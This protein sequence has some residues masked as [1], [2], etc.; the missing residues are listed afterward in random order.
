MNI[1]QLQRGLEEQGHRVPYREG[2]WL[3][4]LPI[5]VPVLTC[6]KKHMHQMPTEKV[7]QPLGCSQSPS[8]QEAR[9]YFVIPCVVWTLPPP[10]CIHYYIVI[11]SDNDKILISY[12]TG[13]G[14]KVF[15]PSVHFFWIITAMRQTTPACRMTPK[16]DARRFK[17][18]WIR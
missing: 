12:Q 8:T 16:T 3:H 4:Y 15:L 10:L 14:P 9:S 1:I 17:S 18:K 5:S 11:L 6:I 7:S 2:Y 13:T